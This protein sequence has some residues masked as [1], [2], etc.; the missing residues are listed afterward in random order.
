M[1][2]SEILKIVKGEVFNFEDAEINEIYDNSKEVKK[3]GI[4]VCIR[5]IKNDGHDFVKEAE[6]NGAFAFI[7]EK[8]IDT[9]K[10][11]IV[12]PDTVVALHKIVKKIYGPFDFKIIGV[13]GTNG[14]TTS[15]F[16][17]KEILE[18]ANEK[19]GMITTLYSSFNSE[20]IETGY[21]CPPPLILYK[22]FKKFK[23]KNIKW[24]V[25][26]ITSHALKLKRFYDFE[27]EGGI[28]TNLTQDHLDFHI[29]M[30]DYYLSKKKMFEYIKNGIASINI[31][32][33]YGKRLYKELNF[34]KVSFG[35]KEECDYKGRILNIL[36]FSMK[37]EITHKKEKTI[38]STGLIGEPNLY[39]ILGVFSLLKEMGFEKEMILEGIKEFKGVPGRLEKIENKKNKKI[40]VDYAHT[41]DA[42]RN[43]LITLK[44][45]NP[46]RLIVIFGAGGNRD[47]SKRPLMGKVTSEIADIVILTSDNP[48]FE[49]ELEIIEDIKKGIKYKEKCLI[50]PDRKEAIRMGIKMMEEDDILLIAGKGHEE[51]QE[52]KGIKYPFNDKKVILEIIEKDEY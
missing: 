37:V 48:R 20:K 27:I 18:K 22:I 4:F 15:V 7:C 47:K 24:C 30:E 13:T 35:I 38:L 8:K 41:P 33:E 49:D 21:T 25:M 6:K 3:G 31:D 52:I 17:I 14:K 32:D 43:V 44:S 12:V 40:Y 23:E 34:K 26:E 2:L 46:K 36:P 29:T 1:K 51:Y 10:P 42:L 5:G 11:F 16:L 28:F 9:K 50:N 45:L 39:N 19:V